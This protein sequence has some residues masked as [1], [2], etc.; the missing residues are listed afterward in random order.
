MIRQWYEHW[1]FLRRIGRGLRREDVSDHVLAA[2]MELLCWHVEAGHGA[3]TFK[4]QEEAM[5]IAAW[6]RTIRSRH[7]I[8]LEKMKTDFFTEFMEAVDW[9]GTDGL[10]HRSMRWIGHED[11]CDRARAAV[12]VIE[13]RVLGEDERM[14]ARLMKIRKELWW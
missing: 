7:Y 9:T 13:A 2:A 14:M 10:R 3:H 11:A 1:R 6:W 5:A 12:E 4:V 8:M